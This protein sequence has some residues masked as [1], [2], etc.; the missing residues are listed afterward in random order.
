MCPVGLLS[1]CGVFYA[2]RRAVVLPDIT[3]LSQRPKLVRIAGVKCAST[4]G[5]VVKILYYISDN[6]GALSPPTEQLEAIDADSPRSAIGK[7]RRQGRL[8]TNWQALWAH[9]LDWS[10]DNGEQRGFETMR[11]RDVVLSPND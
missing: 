5:G 3:S 8:P 7:L 9:F 11:L 6:P 10:S 2:R 1:P 4:W